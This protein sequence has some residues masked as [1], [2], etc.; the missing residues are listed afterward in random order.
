MASYLPTWEVVRYLIFHCSRDTTY[1]QLK[2]PV[3]R[4]VF[5]CA[6]ELL[7]LTSLH[8]VTPKVLLGLGEGNVLAKFWIVLL[9]G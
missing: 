1:A 7:A 6:D 5:C 8:F 4:L 2:I 9:Q 3:N